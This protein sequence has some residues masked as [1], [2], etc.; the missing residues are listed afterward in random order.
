MRLLPPH[1]SRIDR[2]TSIAFSFEGRRY[3]GFD[4]DTVASALAAN[5]VILLGRS[6]KYHRPRGILTMTGD[7]ANTF[8]T[9]DSTPN[10]LADVVP[11]RE[12]MNVMGQHY[13]GSLI[14][15]NGRWIERIAKFLPV[16]FYYRALFRPR[17]IWPLWEKLVRRMAGLGRVS[18]DA[19]HGYYDKQ[20]LFADTVVIGGG[21]AGLSAALAAAER[22]DETVLVERQPVLGGSL[23][24]ARFDAERMRGIDTARSLVAQALVHPKIRVMT[25]ATCTGWFADNYLPILQGNRMFKLRATDVVVATGALEQPAVFR[26]N[27]LPGIMFGSAAQRL[28]R[29]YGVRP[30]IRAVVATA[31]EDGYGVALDLLD[32]GVDVAAIVDISARS[33]MGPLARAASEKGIEIVSGGAL[34]EALPTE[35]GLSVGAV[36]VADNAGQDRLIECDLL[37]LSVGWAPSSALPAHAGAPVLYDDSWHGF[38]VRET[39]PGMRVAGAVN[40][41]WDLDAAL[42]DG[43]GGGDIPATP[44]P[45]HHWPIFPH[46]D[47]KEFVDFDEDLT[48]AD[49]RN[50]VADGFEDIELV[51]RFSTVGMG[52]SQGRQTASNAVRLTQE[53]NGGLLADARGSTNR[54]PAFPE[55]LGALAGRNFHPVRVSAMHERH[56]EAG[57]SM[58][59]A[60]AWLRPA[61]YGGAAN[62]EAEVNAVR[63][64]VAMMDVSTLGG[65]EV[66]GPDAAEFLNRIYT[67]SYLKQP[68]GRSRYVLM[69]NDLGTIVDD[70][71]ACRLADDHF[72]V[73]ATTGNADGVYREMLFRNVQWRLDVDIGNVT[74]A[75]SAVSL[76]GP[77]SRQ[78]LERVC[79]DLDLSAE[80][81]PYMGVREGTVAGIP[82]RL[83]R[84]GFVGELG[85]EIHVPSSMGEALWDALMEAGAEDG[86]RPFGVE[87]QRILRLEKGHIIIGQDSDALTHPHEVDMGWALGKRKPYFNGARGI[88][89]QMKQPMTRRLAGFVLPEDTAA[90]PEE[91]HLV[92]RDGVIA[93]RI[94]SIVRSP[95]L[96]RP[97]GLAFVPPD[98]GEP[99]GRLAIKGP[100][101]RLIEA[102]VVALPFYDPDNKRQAL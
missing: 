16:G 35:G 34:R 94:T 30:G 76:A 99:D 88:E 65:L 45:N 90:L 48:I 52:P 50:A 31:N 10:L 68:V 82:A 95:T 71:V 100:R 57:A 97:I 26:N 8:V 3:T 42:E 47:G 17:G 92:L 62:I 91:S 44:S 70:G 60:G 20:Y 56:L 67:M 93:G 66:R 80:G 29:L 96:G 6:F 53:A 39:P 43:A 25:D 73:T 7:D 102:T 24:H 77:K 36:M 84:V 87:A 13:S 59:I 98:M 55:T 69:C 72:Y 12:G 79:D 11:I 14:G 19:K 86:I 51:K 5:D 64:N 41:V 78:V 49:I 23:N 28:I 1:G 27:D 75:Y 15:D 22:G 85:W 54:P 63:G 89:M 21:A 101:G 4:G 61:C 18:L 9:I 32:A 38:T 83:L 40:G 2:G 81:F 46:P 74:A 33:G 58:L 37:C